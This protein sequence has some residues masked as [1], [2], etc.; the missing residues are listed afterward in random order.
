VR[1][2][3]RDRLQPHPRV[4]VRYP[5]AMQVDKHHHVLRRRGA[6]PDEGGNQTQSDAIRRNQTQS[7]CASTTRGGTTEVAKSLRCPTRRPIR[8]RQPAGTT[9]TAHSRRR[10]LCLCRRPRPRRP[11]LQRPCSRAPCLTKLTKLTRSSG[12]CSRAPCLTKLTCSSAPCSR[13]P[14]LTKL[15]KLSGGD[16]GRSWPAGGVAAP[17]IERKQ[18]PPEVI[19]RHQRSSDAIRGHQTLSEVIRLLSLRCLE[20]S[21][22]AIRRHQSGAISDAISDAP[23]RSSQRARAAAVPV[24]EE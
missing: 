9:G 23:R 10:R 16:R 17:A 12:P 24:G 6:A 18:T 22:I 1:Q 13:A 5:E 7:P 2:D 8:P 3:D 19:R 4:H 15:T 21:S 14:C 11:C 20:R